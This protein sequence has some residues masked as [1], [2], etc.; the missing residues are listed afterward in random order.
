MPE[1]TFLDYFSLV[2]LIM[3]ITMV[4]MAFMWLHE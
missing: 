1:R 2:I 4:V 3:G